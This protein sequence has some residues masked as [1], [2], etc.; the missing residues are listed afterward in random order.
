MGRQ[1]QILFNFV[2]PLQPLAQADNIINR[3]TNPLIELDDSTVG[4]PN[5][6]INFWAAGIS[7]TLFGLGNHG[8]R[9]TAPLVFRVNRQVI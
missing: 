7:Q 4:V 2:V 5:L 1:K 8:P 3:I 6:Q 9:K